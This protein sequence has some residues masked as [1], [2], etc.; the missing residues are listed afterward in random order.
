[1]RVPTTISAF[2]IVMR[3]SVRQIIALRQ[4]DVAKNYATLQLDSRTSPYTTC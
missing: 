4:R 3:G 1:M 2:K